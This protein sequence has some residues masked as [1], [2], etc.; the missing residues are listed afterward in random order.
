MRFETTKLIIY[1]KLFLILYF[2]LVAYLCFI[3][4]ILYIVKNKCGCHLVQFPHQILA[5]VLHE[6]WY[7]I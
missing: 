4:I 6:S 3:R 1:I 5:S 2:I 7:Q